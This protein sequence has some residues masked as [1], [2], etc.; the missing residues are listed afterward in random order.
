MLPPTQLEVITAVV[1]VMVTT[2]HGLL[3]EEVVVILVVDRV[4]IVLQIT[5]QV[6][7]VLVTHPQVQTHNHLAV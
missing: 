1:R 5:A 3:V 4:V 7:V 2:P 6:V